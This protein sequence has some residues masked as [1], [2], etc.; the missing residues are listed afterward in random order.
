MN[1]II[2]ARGQEVSRTAVQVEAGAKTQIGQDIAIDTD[3]GAALRKRRFGDG[4]LDGA[5]ERPA[6]DTACRL[7]QF[8]EQWEPVSVRNCVKN[9]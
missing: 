4:P 3:E 8:E 6:P 5:I 2:M 1:I 9:K 7:E